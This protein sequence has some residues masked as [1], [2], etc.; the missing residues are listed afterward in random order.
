MKTKKQID[1]LAKKELESLPN[2]FT[3][4]VW[5]DG[6]WAVQWSCGN[7]LIEY[8]EDLAKPFRIHFCAIDFNVIASGVSAAEALR[9]LI[10]V[11]VEELGKKKAEIEA[12]SSFFK[13]MERQ[14]KL[15]S[16]TAKC[17]LKSARRRTS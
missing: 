14:C 2:G 1:S 8:F 6:Q 4:R 9:V 13:E 10:G 11:V 16:V 12:V 15:K 5:K 3:Y 7:V 17:R